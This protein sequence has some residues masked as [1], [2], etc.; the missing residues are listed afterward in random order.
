MS[1]DRQD[2]IVKQAAQVVELLEFF[3][4][5]GQPATLS[6]V[7]TK[8]NWPRSSTYNLLSTLTRLGYLYEPTPKGG[9]YP[10]TKWATIIEQ[11]HLSQPPSEAIQDMLEYLSEKTGE[12]AVL[13]VASGTEALFLQVCESSDYVKFAAKVGQTIPLYTT[14]IGLALLSQMPSSQRKRV[15]KKT[16][17]KKFTDETLMSTEDVENV[18]AA[19]LDRGWFGSSG[20]FAENLSGVAL[21]LDTQP[22]NYAILVSGPTERM[23]ERME[24]V[25][26]LMRKA[27]KK[28]LNV[29]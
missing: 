29:E 13:G 14:V 24:Y 10:S 16:S 8:L 6:Q 9:L 22:Y 1:N 17:F 19:S 21:P 28:F 27:A 23:S 15:L 2:K 12:T 26:D 11:I 5:T 7:S 20:R 18:I 4:K 25:A 3:A